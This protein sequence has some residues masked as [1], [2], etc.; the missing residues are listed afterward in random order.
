MNVKSSS[1]VSSPSTSRSDSLNTNSISSISSSSPPSEFKN[2]S[3]EIVLLLSVSNIHKTVSGVKLS[4]LNSP[5]E[6]LNICRS[7]IVPTGV[8]VP[9]HSAYENISSITIGSISSSILV[10]SAIAAM[11]SVC[12]V[13]VV[14]EYASTSV[15]IAI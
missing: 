8:K 11:I 7:S 13:V 3:K 9:I 15:S 1:L 14:I 4:S 10:S 2:S 5:I 12:V 6:T